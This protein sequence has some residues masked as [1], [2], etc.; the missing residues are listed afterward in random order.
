MRIL[1]M[2]K[3]GDGFGVAQRLAYE[4]H[5]V[6]VF[7]ADKRFSR[8]LRGI[9]NRVPSWPQ[10]ARRA[11]LIICDCVGYGRYEDQIRELGRPFLGVNS[12]LDKI[13]LD[14]LAGMEMFRRAG[15][16]IPE[17]IP[18]AN[19][20]EAKSI[21]ESSEWRDG[22]VVKPSGNI[23][24][25]KTMVVK[26]Q[27][28][29]QHAV[30]QLPNP[31]SGILQRIIP[32]VEVSTEGWFNGMRFVRPF[33]HT[34]EEKRFLPGNLGC[35]TGCM[36]NVV[37]GVNSNRLTK[38]TVERV[39]DFLRMIGYRGPFDINTIV[40]ETGAYAL[41]ATSRMGYDAVEALIEG[42]NE[43]AG[44][45]FYDIA[46][47]AKREMDLGEDPMIAVRMSIP[48]WP[49]RRPDSDSFGE[50]VMGLTD[51]RL[52][53]VFLTDVMKDGDEYVTA[54]GDGVLL[55]ATATGAVERKSSP[56]HNDDYTYNARRRVYRTLD[57]ISVSNKQY[58]NDIGSRV[59]ADIAKL[60]SWGWMDV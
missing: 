14:R 27:A 44:E 41:E 35:N 17:T 58:R 18:F 42:L 31:S 57:G 2:G 48:P 29:W 22:W 33:N 6:D 32:G 43:P 46:Q 10:A 8:A 54:G 37:L 4:G 52:R 7:C 36:G 50:P 19:V 23:S 3:E 25:S 20:A 56:K 47:G 34:F 30:S 21:P 49:T 60:Q 12:L 24:T 15:I 5:S 11:D 39:E 9:V 38:A 28:L 51:E 40:N 13:E 53:H 26:D 1:V 45:F 59:N 55:K 16:T